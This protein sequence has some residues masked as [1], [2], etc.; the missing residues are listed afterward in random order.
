MD[1]ILTSPANL[2]AVSPNFRRSHASWQG[3]LAPNRPLIM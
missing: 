2:R 1:S 3:V